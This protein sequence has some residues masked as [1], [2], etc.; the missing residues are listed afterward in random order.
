MIFSELQ[1]SMIL[2]SYHL[3]AQINHVIIRNSKLDAYLEVWKPNQDE[4]HVFTISTH[5]DEKADF[6]HFLGFVINFRFVN[7]LLF[8]SGSGG[9]AG[10][11][12][13]PHP[14]IWRPQLY[15]LEAQCTI[16]GLNKEF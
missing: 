5:M 7:I 8:T 16:Q 3:A 6:F 1:R 15:N 11:P 14:Q 2:H 10:G 4:D 13:P 9:G 12:G